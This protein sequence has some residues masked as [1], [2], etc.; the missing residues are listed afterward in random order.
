[1]AEHSAASLGVNRVMNSSEDKKIVLVAGNTL[2]YADTYDQA[3]TQLEAIQRGQAPPAPKPS[4]VQTIEM[5]ALPLPTSDARINE[6]R[7]HM[8][9]YRELAGQGKWAE[10]GRELETIESLVKK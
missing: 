10:A 4:A 6:I 8:Q 2:V 3:L 7:Q 9:R 5:V 1:M